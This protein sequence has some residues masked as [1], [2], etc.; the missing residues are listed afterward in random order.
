LYPFKYYSLFYEIIKQG[1]KLNLYAHPYLSAFFACDTAAWPL[2]ASCRSA[3][4]YPGDATF[5]LDFNDL[6]NNI[7]IKKYIKIKADAV[8]LSFHCLLGQ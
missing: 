5:V 7:T 8:R 6:K 2:L 1:R 3:N 4:T